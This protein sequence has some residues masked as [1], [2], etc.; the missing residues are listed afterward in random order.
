[1]EPKKKRGAD[2]VTSTPNCNIMSR[3]NCTLYYSRLKKLCLTISFVG[4]VIIAIAY[5]KHSS[6]A[7]FFGIGLTFASILM[8]C[9]LNPIE[10]EDEEYE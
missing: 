8:E 6:N 4:L 3:N 5:F 7:G 1:M 10:E 2:A 9:A